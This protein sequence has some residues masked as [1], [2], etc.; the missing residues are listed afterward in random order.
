MSSRRS[1]TSLSRGKGK[2]RVSFLE[3]ILYWQ[4]Y[5]NKK[6]GAVFP[7]GAAMI[8]TWTFSFL[9]L[10]FIPFIVLRILGHA[11][12][13]VMF[14]YPVVGF[15]YIIKYD[16]GKYCFDNDERKDAFDQREKYCILTEIYDSMTRERVSMH[17]KIFCI[18][19]AGTLLVTA[20]TLWIF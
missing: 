13:E 20:V 5:Y 12:Y 15:I 11:G 18:Y 2:R 17:K 9:N 14:I 3:N 19:I 10:A 1:S 6:I 8:I 4:W 7:W 16:N